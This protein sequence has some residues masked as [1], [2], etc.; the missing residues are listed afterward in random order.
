[1]HPSPG[2]PS[3]KDRARGAFRTITSGA[4][5]AVFGAALFSCA[6]IEA[7]VPAV[8]D[9]MVSNA[10]GASRA[11]LDRGRTILLTTC[12]RCHGVYEPASQTHEEWDHILPI[13]ARK[14]N[15][16]PSDAN[17]LDQYIAAALRTPAT[18]PTK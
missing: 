5:C 1:M 16:S 6:G 15:L 17:Q 3:E 11:E 4:G 13:M 18:T 10:P 12:N 14:A 9:A 2:K 7:H 8:S